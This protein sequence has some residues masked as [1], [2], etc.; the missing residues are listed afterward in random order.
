MAEIVK[1][2][3]DIEASAEEIFEVAADY[4]SYPQWQEQVKKAEVVETDDDGYGTAVHYEV[5][6]LVKMFTYTLEYDY[7]GWPK[8]FTWKLRDGDIKSLTGKY[9]FEEFDDA[10][11]VTYELSIDPGFKV[12]APLR[13]RGEKQIVSMALKGLKKRVESG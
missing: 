3:I 7:K 11:E 13:R 6:A 8:Y 2:S 5:D 4:E 9:T 12:P 1:D 10:T